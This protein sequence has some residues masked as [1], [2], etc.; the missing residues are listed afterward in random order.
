M[1][2]MLSGA[3]EES[4]AFHL[5]QQV[6]GVLLG[7]GFELRKWQ[8]N[9]S[10]VR[11]ALKTACDEP[12]LLSDE[13]GTSVLGLKWDPVTDKL[14]FALK[15]S[16]KCTNMS[17]R[18]VLSRIA[19]LYD[20]QGYIGPVTIVGRMLMQ[21]IWIVKISWDDRLPDRIEKLWLSFWRDI[22]QLEKFKI[23]RWIGTVQATEIH[24]HGFADASS[25][26]YGAVI[27]VQLRKHNQNYAAN[28][29][30]SKSRVA[31]L[32]TVSIPR[33][34]LSAMN[35]L[36]LVMSQT[37]EKMDWKGVPYTLWTDSTIALHWIHKEPYQCE[38]FVANRIASIQSNSSVTAW[39][40][41]PTT[42]NPADL[43]TRGMSAAEIVNN[44]FWLNGPEW[45][46]YPEENW[47][48]GSFTPAEIPR[49]VSAELRVNVVFELTAK[50]LTYFSPSLKKEMPLNE[51]TNSL[52]K[53]INVTAY[54]FRFIERL[55]NA[56]KEKSGRQ[57][58]SKR[59]KANRQGIETS[60][61]D[62]LTEEERAGALRYHIKL[63][64]V[65][66]YKDEITYLSGLRASCPKS[67][68]SSF[69]PV[70]DSFKIMR[71]GGRISADS[72]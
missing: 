21:D 68:L 72:P 33:L 23:P 20:P 36:A 50:A 22:D 65:E 9:S 11:S 45:L 48:K 58:R 71:V 31:P 59:K 27:Y 18:R 62:K 61:Y 69:K 66:Y 3:E 55:K 30:L 64:Q 13:A 26:A 25:R 44:K 28:L 47:P 12:I 29:L 1:D 35:L 7:G 8:S 19:Q 38:T 67:K 6:D 56:V 39:R 54:V 17:K 41:V 70:L 46:K 42:D 32:K 43:I 15:F 2:D 57:R 37:M 49:E 63:V 14:S 24:L 51:H 4:E 5:A 53:L 34:E 10:K 40:H 52:D 60:M 16:P